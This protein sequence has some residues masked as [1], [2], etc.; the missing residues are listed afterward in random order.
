MA[1]V[2]GALEAAFMGR[3]RGVD[4]QRCLVVPIDV[5]KRVAMGLVAGHYGE[6][7]VASSEFPLNEA[8]FRELPGRVVQAQQARDAVM[9]WSGSS[10]PATITARS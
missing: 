10:P 3:V 2:N 1:F 5:G 7:V 9:C 4:L 6:I 8:G